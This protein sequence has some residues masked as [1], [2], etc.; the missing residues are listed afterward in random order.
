MATGRGEGE[1]AG[2]ESAKSRAELRSFAG[3]SFVPCCL[4]LVSQATGVAGCCCGPGPSIVS[5]T[6]PNVLIVG[7]SVS[8]GYIPYVQKALA[9]VANVQHGP[10]NAGGGCADDVRH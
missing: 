2:G 10:D 7:D 3:R 6:Q 4:R 5:S 8:D 9:A 1:R